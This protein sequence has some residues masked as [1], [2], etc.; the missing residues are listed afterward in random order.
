[1]ALGRAIL[2]RPRLLLLD[3]PFAALDEELRASLAADLDAL[4]RERGLPLIVVSHHPADV[5]QLAEERWALV[6]GRLHRR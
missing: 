3:E 5:A 1:V 4:S 6:G 2:A